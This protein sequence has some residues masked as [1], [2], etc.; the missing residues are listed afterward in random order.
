MHRLVSFFYTYLSAIFYICLPISMGLY[1]STYEYMLFTM[2][3]SKIKSISI[4][5]GTKLCICIVYMPILALC[6]RSK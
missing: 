6:H 4:I 1:F 5:P 3:M 2:Y